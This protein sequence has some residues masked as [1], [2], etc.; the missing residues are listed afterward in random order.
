LFS[1]A[2]VVVVVAEVTESVVVDLPLI[3]VV[4]CVLS[5]EIKPRE[6]ASQFSKAYTE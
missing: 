4:T 2:V 6:I 3:F 5:A 1:F